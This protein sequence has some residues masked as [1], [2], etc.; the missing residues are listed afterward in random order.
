MQNPGPKSW[1][2]EISSSR[3][4]HSEPSPTSPIDAISKISGQ[5]S[6]NIG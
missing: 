4:K 1:S 2:F 6:L 3:P 5:V